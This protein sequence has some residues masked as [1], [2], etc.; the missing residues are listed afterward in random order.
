[1]SDVIHSI[2]S[3]EEINR[4]ARQLRETALEADL[5]PDV[6]LEVFE[7]WSAALDAPG[8]R[9]VPGA[10]FLRL[11][12]RR[13]TLQPILLREL[14]PESLH[15][16]W[17]EEGHARLK[18]F[19]LGV[20][21]HWPAG[22]IEIQPVLSLTCALLG[23]NGC[24]VR[25]PSGLVE[26]T[27]LILEKLLEVDQAG[28]L[29][30]RLFLASF[31]HA[32][33]DLHAAIAQTVDGAM[34]WGGAESVSEVRALP[35]PHWARVVVFGP[36]LSVAAMDAGAWGC[37]NERPSWCRRIA[38]DVWQF[39][40]QACSSPQTL[41]LERGDDCDPG[42]FVEDLKCAFQEENRAHPRRE[43]EPALTSAICQAR[44]SWLLDD[45]ANRAWFPGSPDWTILLGKGV[46]IPEPT[47]GRT[48]SVLV[49][50]DL[51]EVVSRFD[52]TVQTL[53][54]AIKDA[55]RE[56]TLAAAAGRHGVDR[57]V[58]LG[59]MH[60]FGSPWDGVDLVRPM[61]RLVRHVC[62]QD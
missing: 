41:F 45:A 24:L 61:V 38:R 6:V 13:G 14:G 36:R 59:Q 52:G 25:V 43:I 15:G 10:A 18:A 30:K 4:A 8:L 40:Q 60:V 32:R 49:A 42:E 51:M 21:G 20:V 39:E 53:G 37:R 55:A 62:S 46:D 1:M 50:E 48:L 58:R 29:T 19:P 5:S 16:G 9:D 17:R 28:L 11:W 31:D 26:T 35:F 47:Q 57:V 44:A 33:T 56:E 7:R 27:R 23:G 22:N 2:T 54:L 12:L 3:P 34:I